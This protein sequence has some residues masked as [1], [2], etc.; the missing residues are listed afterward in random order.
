M[1]QLSMYQLLGN[2]KIPSHFCVLEYLSL[3]FKKKIYI[4]GTVCFGIF[5]S[6]F[7]SCALTLLFH[8][9]YN[10]QRNFIIF[11]ALELA[12][13]FMLWRDMT[14]TGGLEER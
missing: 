11:L 1:T 13:T 8:C 12:T 14:P 9:W 6:F 2:Y 4:F 5:S 10:F 7:I 3:E